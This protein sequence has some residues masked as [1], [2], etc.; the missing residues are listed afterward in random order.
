ME[1]EDEKIRLTPEALEEK[2]RELEEKEKALGKKES[3]LKKAE[4]NITKKKHNLYSKIDVSLNTMD[5]VIAV[6]AIAAVMVLF[7][8][9]FLK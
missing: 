3:L 8:G 2:Q 4:E 5:R 9:M 7:V 1:R 6:L